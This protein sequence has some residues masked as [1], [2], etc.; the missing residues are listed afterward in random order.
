MRAA[1]ERLRAMES[2]L[3]AN[4]CKIHVQG[5]SGKDLKAKLDITEAELLQHKEE[6]GELGKER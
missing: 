1:A 5:N 2:R 4:K 3:A 6:A